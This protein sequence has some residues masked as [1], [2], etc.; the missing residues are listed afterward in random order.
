MKRL[1]C[2]TL[3]LCGL[4]LAIAL[5]WNLA[6]PEGPGRLADAARNIVSPLAVPFHVLFVMCGVADTHDVGT[7]AIVLGVVSTVMVILVIV[8]T[9]GRR[10]VESDSAR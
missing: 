2:L 6:D 10:Q 4:I 9:L 1:A 3:I 5:C 7:A 8:L